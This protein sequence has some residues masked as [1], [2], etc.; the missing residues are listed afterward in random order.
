M[1]KNNREPHFLIIIGSSFG[2]LLLSLLD[3]YGFRTLRRQILWHLIG[4]SFT[5]LNAF[6]MAKIYEKD[7]LKINRIH[8]VVKF[9][10]GI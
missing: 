9:S 10:H 4:Y 1:L 6:V 8:A 2:E 5:I 3:H 7:F